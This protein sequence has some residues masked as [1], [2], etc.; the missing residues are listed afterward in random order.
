MALG[1]KVKLT[2]KNEKLAKGLSVEEL[3]ID[4]KIK[5]SLVLGDNFAEFTVYGISE[6]SSKDFLVPGNRIEFSAGHEDEVVGNIFIGSIMEAT[7]K[8]LNGVLLF[9]IRAVNIFPTAG[10][11]NVYFQLNYSAGT[12]VSRLVQDVAATL[13]L[14]VNGIENIQGLLLANGF[15]YTGKVRGI[16]KRV[17]GILLKDDIGFYVDSDEI[18]IYNKDGESRFEIV[19]LTYE[20]GLRAVK[21]ITDSGVKSAKSKRASKNKRKRKDEKRI[22]FEAILTPKIRPNSPIAI[23]TTGI[24]GTFVVE[25]CEFSGNNYNGDFIVSGEASI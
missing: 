18:L 23:N 1:R 8:K 6:E 19:Y 7:P 21:D 2:V 17:Q 16:F 15:S 20:S 22:S 13:D 24:K 4:F 5:R 11:E 25:A 14:I 9:E 10:K 3:D 12:P